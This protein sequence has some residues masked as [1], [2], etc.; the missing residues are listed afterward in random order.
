MIGYKTRAWIKSMRK[1]QLGLRVLELIAAVGLLIMM[2]L[3]TNVEPL[4]G[5]VL[6]IT[7]SRTILYIV[8]R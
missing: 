6:R 3:I 2:I 1:V 5:W 7:V 8:M 4:C